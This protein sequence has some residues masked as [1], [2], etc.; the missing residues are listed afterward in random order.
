MLDR[1]AVT[2]VEAVVL[3]LSNGLGGALALLAWRVSDVDVQ[4]A[5]H[6]EPPTEDQGEQ[7]RL[8]HNRRVVTEDARLGEAA[9]LLCHALIALIGLFWVLTPQPTNPSVIWWAIAIRAVALGL[10]VLLI[11]KT[12]HHLEARYRFDKPWLDGA[13]WTNL[14]PALRL[15]WSDW[16]DRPRAGRGDG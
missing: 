14:A 1:Q 6:W 8:R 4:E 15:A 11:G 9:R 5:I 2:F 3:L 13:T 10:S 12:L 16:R 7:A